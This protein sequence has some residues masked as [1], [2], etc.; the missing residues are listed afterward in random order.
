MK[1]IGPRFRRA[2]LVGLLTAGLCCLPTNAP[3]AQ[4]VFGTSTS[5]TMAFAGEA[6]AVAGFAG[7]SFVSVANTAVLSTSGGAQEA[8]AMETTLA[9]GLAVGA[10][11][12]AVVG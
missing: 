4:F 3:Q 9:G 11:H 5:A 6:S 7:G 12:A 8:S 10:S 1:V 2:V